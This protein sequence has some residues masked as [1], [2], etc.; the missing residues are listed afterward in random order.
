MSDSAG[1]TETILDVPTDA[2]TMAVLVKEPENPAEGARLPTIVMFHDAPGVRH[3][4]HE[5]ARKLAGAGY[6]VAVPD[7]YHRQGRLIGFDPADAAAD[8]TVG[9]RV[10]ELLGTLTDDG[11]QAD[12]DA[13]LGAMDDLP[14]RLGCIG[15]CLGARA[16]FRTM[17]RLPDRFVVGAAWHPSF[18]V[19]D[20]PDSPHLSAER[21]TGSLYLGFAEADTVM[22][23]ES[24]RPFIDA[25]AGSPGKT[26]IDIHA[27]ADHGFTWPDSPRYDLAAAESSFAETVALFDETLR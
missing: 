15:F 27:G 7:L 1:L 19:D 11:I 9:E 26:I 4:T 6:R 17:M 20:E 13:T 5:F 8:P 24:M 10:R 21:L 18:L 22:P 14:E 25:V 23:V 16:V 12:L 3:A 2:G